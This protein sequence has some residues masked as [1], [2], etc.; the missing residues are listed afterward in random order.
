[1][2][3]LARPTAVRPTAYPRVATSAIRLTP[4]RGINVATAGAVRSCRIVRMKMAAEISDRAHPKVSLSGFIR[5]P[6][7]PT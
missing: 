7:A 4:K 3:A 6:S 1:M 5:T 2:L